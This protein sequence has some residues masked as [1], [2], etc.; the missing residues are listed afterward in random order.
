MVDNPDRLYC[1]D[2]VVHI[3]GVI[4]DEELLGVLP[5]ANQIQKFTV[6]CGWFQETFGEFPEGADEETVRRHARANIMILLGTYLFADK[7]GNRIHIGWI[8]YVAMLGEMGGYS[9]RSAA[10]AWLFR[11]AGYDTFSWPLASRWSGH[12][13]SASG[14]GPQVQMCRPRID[15]SPDVLQV[16]NPEVLEPRHTALWWCVTALIYFTV[17]EWHQIDRV[18]SHFGGVQPRCQPALNINFLMSKDGRGDLG[19]SHD[20]LDWWVQHGKRFFSPEMYLRVPRAVPI[21]VE[22]TQRG[23][24]RVHEMDRVDDVPNRRRFER[25]ACVGTRR[26]RREWMVTLWVGMEAG[27]V[28]VEDEAGRIMELTITAVMVRMTT[29]VINVGLVEERTEAMMVE[30]VPGSLLG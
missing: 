20:F 29:M 19:P 24:G 2:G 1:L 10:L 16:V 26:S 6:N 17:I 3:A 4:N 25:R 9:W 7:C 27:D 5:P 12:N 14:K 15:L 21:S 28:A 11:P 13:P 8:P 18:L 23:V 22:A 30:G